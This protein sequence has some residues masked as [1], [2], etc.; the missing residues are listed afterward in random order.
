MKSRGTAKVL[1]NGVQRLIRL[2]VGMSLVVA[3]LCLVL[4][5]R[6]AAVAAFWGG[7]CAWVPALAY[8]LRARMARNTD[9]RGLLR[10][11]FAGEGFKFAVSLLMF[12]LVFSR[13]PQ[14]NAPLFFAVFIA[15]QLC[16][17]VALLIDKD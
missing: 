14:I 3:L 5:G 15:A 11:Q 6:N 17:F 9:A 4:A 16:Y 12:Y 13:N 2:Q 1:G 10:A 7:T 8:Q